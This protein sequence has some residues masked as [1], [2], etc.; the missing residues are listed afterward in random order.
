[1][2]RRRRDQRRLGGVDDEPPVGA[3][4]AD[5]AAQGLAPGAG[6]RRERVTAGQVADGRRQGGAR[7]LV[8]HAGEEGRPLFRLEGAEGR[9]ARQDEASRALPSAWAARWVG[10]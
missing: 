1:L 10:T 3:G 9:D 6:Q 8:V 5:R 4:R 2:S 7:G